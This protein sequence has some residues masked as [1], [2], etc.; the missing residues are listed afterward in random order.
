MLRAVVL[1]ILCW[2][3]A[4]FAQNEELTIEITEGVEGAVPVAVVPFAGP[5][6]LPVE[7]AQV[8]SSDLARSGRFAIPSPQSYPDRPGSLSDTELGRWRALRMDYLVVGTIQPAPTGYAVVF[9]L[10]DVLREEEMLNLSF[11]V[12]ANDLRRLGHE[13]ADLVFEAIT[14][15]PG[16]FNTRVAYVSALRQAGGGTYSLVVADSDGYSPQVVLRSTQPIMSPAWSPDGQQLAYVSFENN[17]SQI[18]VQNLYTG[19]RRILTDYPGINGAPAWSPNG[20]QLAFTLSMDGN[21]EIYVQSIGG[22]QPQRLTNNTAIDTEPTWLPDGSGLIFTSDRGGGPQLYRMGLDGS[23]PTRISFEGDYNA[24]ASIAPDGSGLAMVHR[25][26]GSFS[27]ALM[28]LQG[29]GVRVLTS[30]GLDESPSFAP[31]GS[32]IIYATQQGGRGVLATTSVDGQ[33]Q[34]TL[35]SRDADVREPAWSPRIR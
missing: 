29:G 2:S 21:P 10:A 3:L 23:R 5:T 27:I 11:S 32:M 26:G 14:G 18:M 34:Q 33:V 35:V 13:I 4:S 30:G 12:G 6:G 15:E 22:G 28:N 7:L 19:E 20:Q 17:R 31:N 25:R 8:V 16:A 9:Q 1:F 24:R